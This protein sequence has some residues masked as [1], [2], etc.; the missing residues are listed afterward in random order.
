MFEISIKKFPLKSGTTG[1]AEL[2]HDL[3]IRAD[4][5]KNFFPNVFQP[6]FSTSIVIFFVTFFLFKFIK[7]F[8][9][10]LPATVILTLIISYAFKNLQKIDDTFYRE[11]ILD[12]YEGRDELKI[13]GST[14]IAIEKLNIESSNLCRNELKNRE[15]ILNADNFCKAINSASFVLILYLISNRVDIIDLT[16][17]IFILILTFEM[18]NILPEV[19]RNFFKMKKDLRIENFLKSTQKYLTPSDPN[20]AIEIKNLNFGYKTAQNII[21]NFNLKIKRGEKIA[22]MG[23]S[24]S[25]KTTLLYLLLN[26]WQPDDGK[27]FIDGRISAATTNN[28]IFSKSVRENFLIYC[29]NISE[30]KILEILKICQLENIDINREIGE[31]GNKISG[32]E[33]CR[34]QTALAIAA[35]SE[36]LILDE[37]TAGLDKDISENLMKEIL[38]DSNKKNRTLIIITHD[39]FIAKKMNVICK[40]YDGKIIYV[41]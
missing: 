1:E 31:N 7:E 14:Q 17:W 5:L 34:L 26:L 23:E 33:R 4:L 6:F 29:P 40:I 12:F 20:I 2:L 27:I 21:K 9:F 15:K 19:V 22:V 36:I 18:I 13:F 16:I 25:G 41:N 30:E 11:K 8:S 38:N 24:G 32:G 28:Y 37:P 3:T 10:I 39:L 35:D